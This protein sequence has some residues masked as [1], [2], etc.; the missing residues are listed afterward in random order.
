MA[1]EQ[2]ITSISGATTE[3]HRISSAMIDYTARKAFIVVESY[4]GA[5]KRAE[6]KNCYRRI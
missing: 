1:L 2:T 3:Y 4:I 6:E 5:A